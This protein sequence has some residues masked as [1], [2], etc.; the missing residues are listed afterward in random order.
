MT[1]KT[2]NHSV[3]RVDRFE[4]PPTALESFMARLRATQR[5]LGELEGCQQNLLLQGKGQSDAIAVVTLVEWS[6]E[7]AMATAKTAMQ[8]HYARE[9]FDPAAFMRELRVRPDMV[10]YSLVSS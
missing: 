8:E 3:F 9:G 10:V 5:L 2:N 7:H 1:S 4:V 6:S